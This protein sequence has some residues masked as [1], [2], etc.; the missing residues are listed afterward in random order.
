[1]WDFRQRVQ[2]TLGVLGLVCL[3]SGARAEPAKAADPLAARASRAQLIRA[4]VEKSPAV[5]AAAHREKA[6]KL[7]AKAA[8]SLPDPELMLE[9][10]QIPISRPY[11]VRDAGMVMV[12][13]KQMVPA[14][15]SLSLRERATESEARVARAER[16]EAAR[17][18]TREV[19]HAFVDYLEATTQHHV[20]HDHIAV[21]ERVLR[22]AKA[23]YAAGGMLTDVSQAEVELSRSR[24]DAAG[25][26][27][28]LRSIKRRLNALM[29]R[30]ADA[31]L[32]PPADPGVETVALSAEEIEKLAQA[33]RPEVEMAQAKRAAAEAE[34][35]VADR[36]AGAPSFSVGGL[37]FPPT[38]GMTEHG[39]GASLSVSLPWV[40]GGP[41]QRRAAQRESIKAAGA[42][43]EQARLGAAAE[44][45]MSLSSVE[46]ALSRLKVLETETLP[47]SRRNLEFALTG[48]ETGGQSLITLL[49]AQRDV[50]DVELEIVMTRA[51]LGHALVEL[52]FAAGGELPKKAV[53]LDAN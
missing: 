45:S 4:A 25:E 38:N 19:G 10:W 35:R 51:T 9:V 16:S 39:Y 50:V 31:P 1:M 52:D 42:E 27:A 34:Q 36:E 46:S 13:V 43:L 29:S 26:E 3:A 17:Q 33:R 53:K 24:A 47:A 23:R 28:R 8:N 21:A 7:K 41:R 14:P 18:L 30:P 37:Y 32:G 49:T 12:G 44:V 2:R 6:A 11:A 5:R 40:W 48:Y 22:V 15:G 20:H